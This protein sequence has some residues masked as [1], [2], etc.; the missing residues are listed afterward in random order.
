MTVAE[1]VEALARASLGLTDAD[2]D[3]PYAWREY[4][5]DGLR[6]ALLVAHHELRACAADLGAERARVA[7]PPT[8]A[9]R[10]LA[11]Y[12]VAHRSPGAD[13]WSLRGVVA[14]LLAAERAFLASILLATDAACAGHASPSWN[15]RSKERVPAKDATGDARAAL[16]RSRDRILAECAG[17]TTAE[18][19]V[20]SRFWEK[21]QY[22][23]RFRLGRFEA[24]LRQHAVQAEKT[25]VA[26]GYPPSE[27]ER[28]VRLLYQALGEVE[29]AVLGASALGA[30]RLAECG[31]V[32]HAR[33]REVEAALASHVRRPG[34][35]TQRT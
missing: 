35:D 10:T 18:L 4:E 6:F 11:Q 17:I 3:R 31:A 20:P 32:V 29:G 15:A 27:A 22:S 21:Q 19:D 30:E 5:E 1:A 23:V 26:I 9:L 24:H 34:E 8:F 13:D 7:S 14:R 25:L 33:A 28:L 2:L 12:Q 16:A